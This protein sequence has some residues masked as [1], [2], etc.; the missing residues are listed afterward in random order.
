MKNEIEEKRKEKLV[1]KWLFLVKDLNGEE[2]KDLANK[3]ENLAT[4]LR[5]KASG[6]INM[7][8]PNIVFSLQRKLH[9]KTLSITKD[10]DLKVDGK[11]TK[12]NPETVQEFLEK[13]TSLN[14]LG[15]EIDL[16]N[17]I[18]SDFNLSDEKDEM[19]DHKFEA[20]W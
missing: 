3:L 10:F 20:W 9:K 16:I 1:K 2:Q 4:F 12:W 6:L 8:W 11:K 19:T 5:G 14:A 18:V 7:P 17:E 13:N 15:A